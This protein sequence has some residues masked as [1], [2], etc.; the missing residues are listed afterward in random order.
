MRV[1][2]FDLGRTLE[3]EDVLEPG[4]AETLRAVAALRDARGAPLGMGL[5]SDFDDP[6]PGDDLAAVRAR[7]VAILDA[8]GIREFFDPVERCVTLSSDLG[9][10]K[11]DERLFRL[12]LDRFERDL[13]FRS[14]LFV[15]E[16]LPHVRAARALGL[17]ALH[18]KGPG[19]TRGDITRL[20]DL[21]PRAEVFAAAPD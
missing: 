20:T 4:A 7:Y 16:N 19:Q 17:S 5:L 10:F 11:P 6:G 3:H 1:V 2:L 8:L 21:V 13:P 14:A 18:Y 15:T 9:V 12:A